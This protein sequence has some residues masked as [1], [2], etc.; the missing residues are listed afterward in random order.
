M[1][2][3]K[4]REA[5]GAAAAA[6][7]APHLVPL[8]PPLV[9]PLVPGERPAAEGSAERPRPAG[10]PF[11]EPRA[12]WLGAH[13][14]ALEQEELPHPE[15][16]R[17]A[18]GLL[19]RQRDSRALLER[20][21]LLAQ[22]FTPRVGL[23]PPDGLLLE[24]KGSLN[25]FGGTAR[26]T[27]SFLSACEAAGMRPSLALA[28]TPL[29]ALAGAR[30]TALARARFAM[31]SKRSPSFDG[32]EGVFEVMDEARLVGALASLPLEVLRWP[33]EV[34]ERLAKVGVRTIGAALRLP[35]AGFARRFGAQTLGS[36]DR[37]VGR[38]ADPRETFRAP[39][40][41][42]MR[43]DCAYEAERHEAILAALA[44]LF[45]RLGEFLEARQCGI[46]RLD[47]RLE[48]R[49]GP[50][51]RCVLKL[52]APAANPHR[53]QALL[54]QRLLAVA[55]PAPVRTCE[56]RSGR[57]V[58]LVPDAGS[59][60][61]PGEHG[62]AGAHARVASVDLI[63]SLRVRLGLEA[64]HG[65][66]IHPTHR[67][68]EASERTPPDEARAA[69]PRGRPA[70]DHGWPARPGPGEAPSVQSAAQPAPQVPWPAFRRPLWLLSIPEPLCESAG[71]PRREGPLRLL[72]E[73]ERIETGWWEGEEVARD[74]YHALDA[75]G[76][77]LWIFR[78]RAAPHRWFLQ[79]VFG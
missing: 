65:L 57:L 54:A 34:L 58:P 38:A 32:R 1:A 78:E 52:V 6:S 67:P 19:H 42:R 69:P 36:L 12:L 18:Q 56:L 37:L 39:E 7:D 51:T 46:D 45:E 62:G 75:R 13:F 24:V 14:P 61:Q 63:E 25:L 2:T 29:A 66:R 10:R 16:A 11:L 72:G 40:R 30:F 21:A 76:V 41:F 73:P 48:H 22:R 17:L 8:A 74:Y 33:A 44:P 28:P 23:A 47:C 71:L 49:E 27:G 15:P 4:F 59:L 64:V 70:Q 9:P 60:W 5:A 53:L 3:R 31:R 79:G 20:L 50:P 77:R 68:E 35:R 26:L 43:R 55:L